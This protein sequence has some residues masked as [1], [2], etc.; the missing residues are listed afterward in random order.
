MPADASA[1]LPPRIEVASAG[2]RIALIDAARGLAIAAMVIYHFTWDLSLQ[3]LIGLDPTADPRWMWFARLIAGTF[4]GVVGVSLVLA[5]RRGFRWGPHLRRVGIIA[6]AALMITAVTWLSY[7]A[8]YLPAFVYFGILHAIAVF[9]L[10][11]VPFLGMPLLVVAA[12]AA[13]CFAAPFF[14]TGPAFNAWP[15]VWL[16]LSPSPPAAVD[17]VPFFP[18]FGCT[19]LGI[20]GAR[21]ALRWRPD[22]FWAGWQPKDFVSRAI[23]TAGRWS[24]IIY[25]VHQP[26]LFALT[27]VAAAVVPRESFEQRFAEEMTAC[28]AACVATGVSDTLCEAQ[29]TCV[30][31][32]LDRLG[33]L[34]RGFDA[35]LTPEETVMLDGALRQCRP[36]PELPEASPFLPPAPEPP[37]PPALPPAEPAPAPAGP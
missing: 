32:E 13:L 27:A 37:V 16:G 11:A 31:G 36:V 28:R 8:G 7:S 18:W 15:L 22:S 4:L 14:L 5:S 26:I 6:A 25:L 23:V 35:Q 9:S 30:Y 10:A 21:L 24:L 3:G 34:R 12:A 1:A 17:Y 19:L 20:L 33:L 29:C 2:A